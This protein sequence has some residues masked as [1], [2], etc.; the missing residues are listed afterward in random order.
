M[1]SNTQLGEIRRAIA[2]AGVDA[3]LLYDF[4]GI[5]P[6]AASIAGISGMVTRRYF[7]YIPREGDPVAITHAIEQGP[8]EN[9]PAEWTKIVYSSWR[10]LEDAL[11]SVV[12]S[13]RVAMEYSPGDAVPY[14]DRI[15]A[16]VIEMVR[17][18]GAEVVTSADLVTRIYAVWTADQLASHERAAE[19]IARIAREAIALAG[20]RAQSGDPIREYELAMLVRDKF[21]QL[22]LFTDHGPNVSVGLNAAN[23]HYEPTPERSAILASGDI[24]LID[25]WARESDGVYADQTWMGSLGAPSA[26]NVAIWEA[27]RGARDAA[28]ALLR[29]R[30]AAG[31]VVT[32]GEADD[33]A[34]K[35]ITTRGFG[36]QFIHRTG[37]SIDSRDLHGSGPNIDNLESRDVRRLLPGIGFSI[38][39][40]IYIPGR[41][42]MRSEVNAFVKDTE[43]LVTPR[44][45]QHDLLIV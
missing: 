12:S 23:P 32:G 7:C 11:T 27:V 18:A 3:W 15:P 10:E 25:L 34:R 36:P 14:L 30:I 22:G 19:H 44:T 6:I 33:A 37:H 43:L 35:F 13:R 4:R 28:L 26:E 16:G 24:V 42:G 9:W 1:L 17:S 31:A 39:P 40:G 20:A 2:D 5:N 29:E 21:A 45:P 8:W 38:E 41:V